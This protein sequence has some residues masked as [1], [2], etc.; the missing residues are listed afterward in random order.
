MSENLIELV[1]KGKSEEVEFKKSTTQLERA[2]KSVCS[3]L[4]HKGGRVFFGINKGIIVGHVKDRSGITNAEYRK[5]FGIS[6]R[7]ALGDLTAICEKVNFSK[8]RCNR[9]R[10]EVYSNPTRTRHK[11]AIYVNKY[12]YDKEEK[13]K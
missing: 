8:S 6:D 7:T 2:L 11:P 12:K 13:I 4:N 3:F 1:K 10:N 5:M 9:E